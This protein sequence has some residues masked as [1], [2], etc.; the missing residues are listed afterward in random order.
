L[1]GISGVR[2]VP[3]GGALPS[4]ACAREKSK[5]KMNKKK[6]QKNFKKMQQPERPRAG[7]PDHV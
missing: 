5:K 7:E 6:I 3:R 4:S 1:G 2:R